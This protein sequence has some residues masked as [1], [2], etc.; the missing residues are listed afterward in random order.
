[1]N[2]NKFM[3]FLPVLLLVSTQLVAAPPEGLPPIEVDSFVTNDEAN[4]VPVEVIN[5]ASNAVPV[6]VTESHN[7]RV[8]LHFRFDSDDRCGPSQPSQGIAH[9]ELTDRS[10]ENQPFV[11]PASKALLITHFNWEVVAQPGDWSAGQYLNVVVGPNSGQFLL[12]TGT[13]IT[14]DI[15]SAA[16]INGNV[17]INGGLL[18]HEGEPVCMFSTLQVGN[19]GASGPSLN[20]TKL[21]GHLVDQ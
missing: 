16:N 12:S 5:D 6:R 20:G 13:I 14:S 3:A 11:V 10:V 9:L 21:H 7:S 1:M 2:M 8:V 18:F 19:V 17:N 4:A 15:A